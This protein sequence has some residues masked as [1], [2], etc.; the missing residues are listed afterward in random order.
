[1]LV[2]FLAVVVMGVAVAE[3]PE[4]LDEIEVIGVTPL[5]GAGLDRDKVPANVQSVTADQLARQ[6]GI[7]V[8][9][10]MDR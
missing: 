6:H 1:M 2:S 8:S 9:Q 5:R 10:Y 7:D 3:E 4:I